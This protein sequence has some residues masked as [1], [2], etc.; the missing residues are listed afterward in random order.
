MASMGER[1]GLLDLGGVL[2]SRARLDCEGVGGSDVGT[3]RRSIA[4]VSNWIP[5]CD[6]MISF[7]SH[8]S[9]MSDR[10]FI[11]SFASA[12]PPTSKHSKV[13]LS[14]LAYQSFLDYLNDTPRTRPPSHLGIAFPP[15]ARYPLQK[16]SSSFP[17][18]K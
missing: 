14:C 9:G 12:P 17:S 1:S 18:K 7:T 11:T 4:C 5:H 15:I 6:A 16:L 2:P 10:V 13:S 8:L 3:F